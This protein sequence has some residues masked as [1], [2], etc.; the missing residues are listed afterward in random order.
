MWIINLFVDGK[1]FPKGALSLNQHKNYVYHI[2]KFILLP[3]VLKTLLDINP[4]I[5]FDILLKL[6]VHDNLVTF[7]KQA[8]ETQIKISE[9]SQKEAQM[10]IEEMQNE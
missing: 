1:Q 6:Y 8:K 5:V 4:K 9:M 2:I 7:I 3:N 10:Q